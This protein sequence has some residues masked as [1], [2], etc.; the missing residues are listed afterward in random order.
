M[1]LKPA[2]DSTVKK[3]L[4]D[5]TNILGQALLSCM[6]MLH[7]WH[8]SGEAGVV[9]VH[10]TPGCAIDRTN[11]SHLAFKLSPARSQ[12]SCPPGI[13]WV[14]DGNSNLGLS[15]L[16]SLTASPQLGTALSKHKLAID[17]QALRLRT[18]RHSTSTDM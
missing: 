13:G 10:I 16:K 11:E 9:A 17:R 5:G 4:A 6:T 1:E 7:C 8:A 2:N 15:I 3:S 14:G 18:N 12:K